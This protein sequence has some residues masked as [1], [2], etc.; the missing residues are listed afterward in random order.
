M[1]CKITIEAVQGP[2]RGKNF[3]FEEHDSFLFGRMSDCHAFLPD[4][5]QVSRHHF[6]LEVN[7]PDACLR[8]LGSLNGT[9]INKVKYG[10]RGTTETPEQGAQHRHPEVALKDGDEIMVGQTV[11]RLRVEIPIICCECSASIPASDRD[12]CSWVGGTFICATCKALL[13]CQAQLP[14]APKAVCCKRCGKDVSEEVGQGRRGDYLCQVCQNQAA[15]DPLQLLEQML[16]Q[17]DVLPPGDKSI[18]V[19]GYEVDRQLRVGGFGAVYLA[20]RMKDRAKVAIKVM[21]SK[22]AVDKRSREAFLREI[23]NMKALQHEHILPVLESGS[24]GTGFYFV[25]PFCDGGSVGDLMRASGGKLA[26]SE[27]GPIMLQALKGLAFAHKSG[28]VHRDLK[29]DNL[30][31]VGNG[32]RRVTKVADFGLTKNFQNA[33]FSG[34]TVTGSYAG[35]PSFMPR[36]QVVNYRYM[37]PVSDVWSMG[38]TLYNM[39]TG[40]IPRD[41]PRGSDPIQIILQERVIPLLKRDASVPRNVAEVIDRCLSNDIKERYQDAEQMRAALANAL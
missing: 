26:L 8:D 31:L 1:L 29:P 17:A 5:N 36:E 25:M 40:H 35:T 23:E 10:G 20:T 37:K 41:F 12:R 16:R 14:K 39:L 24:A 22:I 13:E 27:A 11:L 3:C 28:Y 15:A 4:D 18:R 32:T 6:I 21:L 2:M 9:Y 38:A 30:L 19:P 7:P 33:G 34:H